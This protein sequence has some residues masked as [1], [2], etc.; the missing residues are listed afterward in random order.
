[1][2]TKSILIIS[3]LLILVSSFSAY[4]QIVNFSGEW[5]LN[6]EKTVLADNQLFLSKITI[7]VKGDSLLTNR[8][9]ENSAG[10]EY[11][12]DEN[13]SPDGKESKISIY[14]MPRTSKATK[15]DGD[16]TIIIESKTIFNGQNGEDTLEAKE[17]WKVDNTGNVLTLVFN[18]K[19]SGTETPGTNYYDKVK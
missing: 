4:S 15:V 18:N 13:L 16:G 14:E 6:K 3:I 11:P 1:M 5:I 8:L 9:Y 2:K 17:T 19:M 7:Q 12:F 10:E